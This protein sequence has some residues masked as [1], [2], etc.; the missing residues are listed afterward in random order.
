MIAVLF[1]TLG[2]SSRACS[3]HALAVLSNHIGSASTLRMTVYKQA[4]VSS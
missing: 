1:A 3:L 2:G 4:F